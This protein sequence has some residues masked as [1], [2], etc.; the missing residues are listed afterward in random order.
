MPLDWVRI[1]PTPNPW[2]HLVRDAFLERWPMDYH[3]VEVRWD[4]GQDF[5]WGCREAVRRTGMSRYATGVRAAESAPRKKLMRASGPVRENT[6]SPMGW[7]PASSVWAYLAAHD[8]PI[9]PAYAMSY[10]GRLDRDR[11]RVDSI[12]GET[13]RGFGRAEWEQRYA[14]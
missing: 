4:Q 2:C 12:G 11:I 8:L 6:C 10:G 14:T 9:H 13:G 7:W 1:E 3:E 5:P